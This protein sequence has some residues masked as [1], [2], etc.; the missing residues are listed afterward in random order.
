MPRRIVMPPTQTK[1]VPMKGGLDQ[2][3]PTILGTPGMVKESV[4]FECVEGPGGG[5]RRI[6]GYEQVDGQALATDTSIQTILLDDQVRYRVR[7]T[8]S[9]GDSDPTQAPEPGGE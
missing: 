3:T 8:T 5:Y 7:V 1:L 6:H 4:N 9:N 2:I